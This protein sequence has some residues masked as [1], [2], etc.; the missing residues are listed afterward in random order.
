MGAPAGYWECPKCGDYIELREKTCPHCGSGKSMLSNGLEAR[1]QKRAYTPSSSSSTDSAPI[2]TYKITPTY[3]TVQSGSA[4]FLKVLAFV[5]WIG[6]LIISIAGANVV[7][8][9]D[10]WGDPKTS[11][12]FITFI[13]SFVTYGVLGGFM[14]CMAEVVQN[15]MDIA[16]SLRGFKAT[17]EE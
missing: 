17:K 2:D 14:F 12:S 6:G 15:I 8:S 5:L 4:L 1:Y 3:S 7:T 11:F 10:R 9:V 16:V 13:T